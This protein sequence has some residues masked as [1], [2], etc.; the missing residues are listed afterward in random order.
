MN[1]GPATSALENISGS[2][3]NAAIKASATAR[4]GRL[5]SFASSSARFVVQS[6][7]AGSRGMASSRRASRS[8]PP[9]P[10]C[11]RA[12]AKPSVSALQTKIQAPRVA[13]QPIEHVVLARLLVEHVHHDLDV[14][15]QHPAP[16][17]EPFDVPRPHAA[18]AQPVLHRLGDR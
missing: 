17:L 3:G 7:W 12:S 2:R 9:R 16:A 13:P 4:G 6:P 15:E 11:F 5:A 18:L 8:S 1:P 10:A 14:V